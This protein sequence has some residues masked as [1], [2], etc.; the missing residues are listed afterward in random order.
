M[1]KDFLLEIHCEEIPAK[2]LAP[3]HSDLQEKLLNLLE[4]NGL[5]IQGGHLRSPDWYSPRK[6]AIFL[7]G[8]LEIQ[9]DIQSVEVGPSKAVC[10]DAHG[11]V[12]DAGTRFAE[13]WKSSF[14]E[15]V[16]EEVK[17]KKGEYAVLRRT[18]KGLPAIQ[19]LSAALPSL[20]AS[21][22]V[23]KA[24][25][26]GHSSFVFVRPIR[27]ILCLLGS[28]V[29]PFEIDGVQSSS[30]TLG[31]RL[32][33]GEIKISQPSDYESRL[34]D[35]Q[36][37]VSCQVR[38]HRLR[39]DLSDAASSIHGS[40]MPDEVLLRGVSEIVEYPSVVLGKFP[41]EFL[42]LPSSI[43]ACSLREH[44]KS[45]C[46]QGADGK[47]LPYFLSVANRDLSQNIKAR[48]TITKGNEWVL[49]ARLFDAQFFFSEDTK[50][51]LEDKR[52]NLAQ[53]TFIRGAGNYLQKTE[54]LVL[55]S[56]YFAPTFHLDSSLSRSAASLS[57]LDLT[58]Q[59]VGEFPELQGKVGAEYLRREGVS[60]LISNAIDEHYAPISADAPLPLTP[61]GALLA[62][63]D[64]LDTL[65]AAYSVGQI[66]TGSKDPL[67]LRRAGLGLVRILRHHNIALSPR[68]AIRQSL[69]IFSK[70]F[71]VQ[72]PN[73]IEEDLRVFWEERIAFSMSQENFDIQLIRAVMAAPWHDHLQLLLRCRALQKAMNQTDF[74]LLIEN[75]KRINNILVGQAVEGTPSADLLIAASEKKLIEK[76]RAIETFMHRNELDSFCLALCELAQPLE[77]FFN[78][79]MVLDD[80]LK[81]RNQRLQLLVTLKSQFNYIADF[82]KW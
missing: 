39:K 40:L 59:M 14:Q 32:A 7:P 68:E 50:T 9:P 44:Q 23:P 28:S 70:Q 79:V 16:F 54:R 80:N 38:Q 64:K 1:A 49:N 71:P 63:V 34:A 53:L 61:L 17:G 31:H 12:T 35:H 26:W 58:T 25:R 52:S 62:V 78:E 8:I 22:S 20:I 4:V 51:T 42:N 36:V 45:F 10:L 19:V 67:G 30:S 69:T 5:V 27:N 18:V 81:I 76:I 57:K 43:L 74:T 48:D 65:V 72:E 13:K 82:S 2:F 3:L 21:L 73:R 60:D 46:V 6:I 24:M 29:I 11:Q 56:E 41:P 55:L 75:A 37:I 15:V 66:P 77:D 33:K 47:L